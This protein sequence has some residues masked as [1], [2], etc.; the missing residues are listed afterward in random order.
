MKLVLLK[1]GLWAPGLDLAEAL[2]F[3]AEAASMDAVDKVD[4]VD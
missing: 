3:I 2:V 4:G 1:H